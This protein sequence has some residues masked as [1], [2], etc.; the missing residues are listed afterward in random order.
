M[1]IAKVWVQPR[2]RSRGVF[3]RLIEQVEASNGMAIYIESIVNPIL[4]PFF[5]RRG[6]TIQD[7]EA[8]RPC[9][10]RLQPNAMDC[11]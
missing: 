2:A 9:F 11:K 7:P 1:D 4:V 5:A 10:Y 3:T 8:T 6:Y